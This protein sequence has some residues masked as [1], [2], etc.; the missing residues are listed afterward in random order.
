MQRQRCGWLWLGLGLVGGACGEAEQDPIRPSITDTPS[1]ATA[2]GQPCLPAGDP[3]GQGLRCVSQS[4]IGTPLEGQQGICLLTC[5]GDESCIDSTL[6]PE[7]TACSSAGVCVQELVPEGGIANLRPNP[8]EAS[9]LQ[10][11]APGTQRYSGLQ[12]GL[13]RGEFACVKTCTADTDCPSER[14]DTC[15]INQGTLTTPN[16]PPG[17]CA[18]GPNRQAGSACSTR[19][20]TQSCGLN[21]DQ[22]GALLCL[23]IFNQT[24]NQERGAGI[25]MQTCGDLDNDPSTADKDCQAQSPE[26]PT[27]VCDFDLLGSTRVGVCVDECS[28]FPDSCQNPGPNA[29]V[30]FLSICVEAEVGSTLPA[31]NVAKLRE[32]IMP[33]SEENCAGRE[34]QCPADAFCV[35][36]DTEGNRPASGVCAYGCDP[37]LAVDQQGCQDKIIDGVSS[38]SC[39]AFDATNAPQIGFL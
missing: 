39:V 32:N 10:D 2:E 23:D 16:A 6:T 1:T 27:P 15:N 38:P 25:C 26:Q 34:N 37:T 24:F 12:F 11:C 21:R 30:S 28:A 4:P 35:I 8:V 20:A 29:C 7:A 3:C 14:F 18:Q 22:F 31:Y 13:N 5:M 33:S 36:V 17:I 19:D 9:A